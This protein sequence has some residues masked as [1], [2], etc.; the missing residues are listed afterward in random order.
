MKRL[1]IVLFP[2]LY[3]P[4]GH[5]AAQTYQ[6][7]FFKSKEVDL[8]QRTGIDF[9]RRGAIAYTDDF[10]VEFQIS[11]RNSTI[12]Y[13]YI[14]QLKDTREKH[15]IDLICRDEDVFI[16]YDK[17]ETKLKLG[18][19]AEH[20]GLVNRWLNFKLTV[21]A[22]TG[23][24]EMTFDG[25]RV[26]DDLAFPVESK[27]RWT[28][29][30]VNR[31]GFNIDEVAPMAVR[32]VQFYERGLLKY[33][34]PLN[35]SKNNRIKD[36]VT[37]KIAEIINPSW[38]LGQHQEWKKIRTLEFP[39]LPQVA[40]NELSEEI[41][42]VQRKAGITKYSLR[43]KQIVHLDYK[44]G[45]P[46]Y[47]EAQQV[48]FDKNNQLRVYSDYKK[49]APVFDEEAQSWSNAFDSLAFL[50]KYWHHNFLLH[51][52]DSFPVA[53]GGYGY[54]TYFNSIRKLD[55]NNQWKEL[56]L[57][58]D[59]FAPRYLAS[60]G[61]S[62]TDKNVFYLFGGLGNQAGKQILGKA[63]YYDLYKIDFEAGYISKIW[64]M[65]DK[66]GNATFTPVN[67]LVVNEKESSFYTLCFSHGQRE[68]NLQLIKASLNEPE[69]VFIGSKIPYN[70]QDIS[71][72]ADLYH[73]KTHNK[74]LA[75]LIM[76][77]D[78]NRFQVDLY[79]INYPPTE[80]DVIGTSEKLR[81]ADGVWAY[82]LLLFFALAGLVAGL[83]LLL[84]R[85]KKANS[86]KLRLQQFKSDES[87]GD[88]ALTPSAGKILTF[89]GF[90][91]FN[92]QEEDV[93]FKF[94]ST[95]KKLFVL[96][97]LH[98][99]DENKGISS[100]KMQEYM[101]PD[102]TDSQAK[103]NRGVNIKKL[104]TVLADIGDVNISFD[105]TY[106]RVTHDASTFCDIEFISQWYSGNID[107]RR[108]E[109]FDR[110]ISVLSRGTFLYDIESEWLNK[111]KENISTHIVSRLEEFCS[112]LSVVKDEQKLLQIA[113]VLFIFDEMNET[114]LQLKCCI[115]VRQGKHSLALEAYDRFTKL[116]QSIYNE[117]FKL[118][119]KEL[120][121]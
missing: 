101:W 45:N 110:C 9:S 80:L 77:V 118:S 89:G 86:R 84:F 5:T 100:K 61:Q 76:K 66:L 3:L 37:G 87:R 91:V 104:R 30:V 68:T 64:E 18:H 32:N 34:W 53:I 27:L 59:R 82:T 33:S 120:V 99:I 74:L 21:N 106:W 4:F 1:F 14:F 55:A 8:E 20:V 62:T 83:W 81:K 12:R 111:E 102:K 50:P 117:A 51:P 16:V 116:Y 57:K 7:V 94:S 70:F 48:F 65:G 92:Q 11:F 19:A 98:T 69:I 6:G 15:Q 31:Y 54:F 26:V 58:G 63:F 28:F 115:L 39:E 40:Y 56:S 97:L 24:A 25:Q 46:F 109:V 17:K 105:G 43:E 49:L 71:S 44:S 2:L 52:V 22:A 47:E 88:A 41:Y 103:N 112:S 95:L 75:L 35:Y 85:K 36:D 23:K 42:F 78:D 13:G 93:T 90:K 38:V 96:I 121:S 29:G 119:F 79:S 60:L 67:S 108:S 72:Y 10:T 113:D 114:A 73:W 107:L